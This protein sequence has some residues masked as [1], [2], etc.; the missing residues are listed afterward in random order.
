[1]IRRVLLVLAAVA[2]TL[3]P[4]AALA[5]KLSGPSSA[6]VGDSVTVSASGLKAGRYALT[7]ASD[8]RPGRTADCVA[9][10]GSRKRA[11][12]GKVTLTRVIPAKLT[13]WENDSVRLGRVNVTPGAYHLIVSVPDGPSGSSVKHS[14]VRRALKIKR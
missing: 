5:A 1:M 6:R 7:L 4:A 3:V 9:R 10:L 2:M 12:D 14:F 13:C 8:S 11:R